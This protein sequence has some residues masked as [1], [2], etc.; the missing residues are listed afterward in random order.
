MVDDG[1]TDETPEVARRMGAE[2][3]TQDQGGAGAARNR[4]AK[5]ARGELLL[6]T[7]ADCA[8]VGDWVERLVETLGDNGVVAA[9][10]VTTSLQ[11]E[12]AARFAQLEYDEK[13]R[14]LARHESVE[15]VATYSAGVPQRRVLAVRGVRR[16]LPGRHVRGPGALLPARGRRPQ[17][18]V[19]APRGGQAPSPHEPARPHAA[20]VRIGYAKARIGRNHP[21]KLI[22]D[23]YT[24]LGLKL[25]V[26]FAGVVVLGLAVA[27]V[28]RG[29]L[30][31]A[32]AGAAGFAASADPL[33]PLRPL[34][35]AGAHGPAARI[36]GRPG[37]RARQR[38]RRRHARRASQRQPLSHGASVIVPSLTGDRLSLLLDSLAEQT[39]AHQVIVVDNGCPDGSV[40]RACERHPGVERLR[41]ERNLG[42]SRAV[43]AGATRA[44]GDVL[45]MVNDDVVCDPTF[46]E[47]L[48]SAVDPGGGVTMATGVLRDAQDPHLIETAGVLLDHTL[49]AFDY[50]NGEPLSVLSGAADP[51]CP[52]GAAAAFDREAFDAVGG[53]YERI[54]AYW[55]EVELSLRII[56]HG[57]RCKLAAGAQ[58]L[59]A[60]PQRWERDRWERTT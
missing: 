9:R 26:G 16:R 7:D 54:F 24:P 18:R 59:T 56:R 45:V 31:L 60:T 27:P 12:P 20:Q 19:R 57:G 5:A 38:V 11:P 52:V 2:V 4:G 28:R 15:L 32:A 3:I 23:T 42:F 43:N 21:D 17:D 55:E 50:L 49:L 37:P 1:S 35:R 41:F 13:Y 14:E 30:R 6:F 47:E 53:F 8:P 10:G 39:I 36:S 33:P 22:Q 44:E 48:S 58:E 51:P 25:Q 34:A 29:G 40:E 46:V